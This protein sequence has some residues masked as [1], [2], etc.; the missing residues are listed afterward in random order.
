MRLDPTR[1]KVAAAVMLLAALPSLAAPKRR[2]VNHPAPN[3]PFNVSLSGTV[4]DA[5]TGAPVSGA[6][7]TFINARTTT[8]K[9]GKFEINNISGFGT[10]IPLRASRSGYATGTENINGSGT[11]TVTLRL[12]GRPTVSVRMTSGTTL[13]LDDDSIR[14]GYVQIFSGYIS[15]T[16]PNF[17][18]SDGTKSAVN[19]TDMKRILGPA[20][21]V[22]SASCCSRED[23]QLQRVKLELRNGESND[24]I[25]TDSCTGFLYDL[26]GRDHVSGDQVF[27]KF[28]EIAEVVFP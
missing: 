4:I 13:Q 23:Q 28:S 9:E 8:T 5:T 24:V 1:V 3:N 12:Q 22:L 7:V 25:F 21:Q 18:K 20:V 16:S 26:L 2:A 11:K 10:N 19:V 27:L 14:M 17:C 6:T 15:S